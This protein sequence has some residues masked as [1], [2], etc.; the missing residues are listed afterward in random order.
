VP[1]TSLP[2]TY[3]QAARHLRLPDDHDQPYVNDAINDTVAHVQN[4]IEGSLLTQTVQATHYDIPGQKFY[5]PRGPVQ[6]I[7]SVTANGQAIA[8]TLYTLEGAGTYDYLYCDELLAPPVIVTYIAGYATI[9][10]DL[11]RLI[12]IQLS[13]FYEYR[14]GQS[15]KTLVE[16]ANGLERIYERYRRGPKVM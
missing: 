10:L 14:S 1:P 11:R 12:L 6:S 15:E 8:D 4:E 7:V 3:Q 16:V 5:L 13:Q 9:P 2:I